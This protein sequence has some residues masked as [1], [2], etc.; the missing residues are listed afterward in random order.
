MQLLGPLAL[1]STLFFIPHEV[2]GVPLFGF[3]LLLGGLIAG[4]IGWGA[5]LIVRRRP[6]HEFWGTLPFWGVAAAIVVLV[7]PNVEQTWADGTPIGLPIRGYGIMVL[8]GLLFGIG[9]S[10]HR[11]KQLGIEPDTIIGLGFSMMLVGVIGARLFYVV[12]KWD[13]FAAP[14][15]AEQLRK[16]VMLTEG[17]LVI[18]GGVIGGLVGGVAFCVRH[19]LK[20]T[21]TADLVAPGFLVGLAFGRIGCLLHGCC[22]GGVCDAQLPAIQFPQGSGPYEAQL[23]SGDVLGMDAG[24]RLPSPIAEV[25]P[26]SPA[27]EKGIVAGQNLESIQTFWVPPKVG[28]DPLAPPALLA[29]AVVDGRRYSF[30]PAEL[31]SYSL[32]THPSQLYASFNALLL[33]VL[34]WYLQPFPDRDGIT[35]CVAILLYALTRFLLEGVRS[36]EAGQFGTTLTVAQWVASA[37]AIGAVLGALAISRQPIGRVWQWNPPSN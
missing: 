23:A 29:D 2:A 32:P 26:D 12:Q 3:G 31:P 9:I 20:L 4:V 6:L 1:R 36:D 14:S 5:W 25:D 34:I 16:I 27:A 19:K 22:F 11:G 30:A 37:S 15:V 21:A 28:D 33:C 7:L 24:I 17:G 10:V 35:F 13:E 8:L 18:Y